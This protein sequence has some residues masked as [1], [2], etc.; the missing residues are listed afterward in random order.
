M[1]ALGQFL[2]RRRPAG[3]RIREM[4]FNKHIDFV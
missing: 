2:D 1:E 3:Q 4:P